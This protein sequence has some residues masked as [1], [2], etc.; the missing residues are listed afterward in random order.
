MRTASIFKNGKNQAVRLP[1]D[2][3]FENVK[4]VSIRKEG[5]S[6]ILTPLKKDWLSFADAPKAD[7]DFLK[8]RPDVLGEERVIF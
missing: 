3:E 2:L 8:E 1:R 6:I 7:D 4:E 5:R